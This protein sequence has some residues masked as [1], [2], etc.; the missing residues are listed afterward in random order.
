MMSVQLP[1]REAASLEIALG[2]DLF[3]R[4]LIRELAGTL[5]DVI[6]T[7]DASGYISVVGVAIG[8]QMDAT[9]RSAF[10][11]DRLSRQQVTDVLV[12]LKRRIEGDF[13]VIEESEDRIVL[14]NRRCPF[15][16]MV[17]DRPSLCMMTSNVFGHIVSQNLG[18]AGVDL[19]QTIAHRHAGCRVV[20]HL[21][22]GDDVPA[23]AREYFQ[24]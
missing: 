7:E 19:E 20:I 11:V 15:G 3:L 23:T 10:A 17:Q 1:S 6:G 2:R 22:P 14:G 8:E 5:Q 16:E 12:D 18:Y 4:S 24:R 13:H 9:Y 21:R